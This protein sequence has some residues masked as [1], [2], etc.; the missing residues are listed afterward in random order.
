MAL[1]HFDG[2]ETMGAAGADPIDATYSRRQL[3]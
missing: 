2:F 1:I 3:K